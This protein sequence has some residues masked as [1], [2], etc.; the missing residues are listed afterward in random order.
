MRV[1]SAVHVPAQQT[2][3]SNETRRDSISLKLP[4]PRQPKVRH[5]GAPIG[6][7]SPFGAS[8]RQEPRENSERMTNRASYKGLLIV[9]GITLM[10]GIA[11][12]DTMAASHGRMAQKLASTST[13]TL[14]SGLNGEDACATIHNRHLSVI[15]L[16]LTDDQAGT[17]TVQIPAFSSQA[18]CLSDTES[19]AVECI[20]TSTCQ[21]LWSVDSF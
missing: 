7:W 12:A 5:S 9:L 18:L 6:H 8:N 14:V 17:S 2:G 16:T 20:G 10:S 19:V 11:W 13:Q 1:G 15:E 4:S 21:F 3:L